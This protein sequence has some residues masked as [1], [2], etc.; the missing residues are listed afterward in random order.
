MPGRIGELVKSVY[1]WGY[2]TIPQKGCNNRIIT[3]PRGRLLGGCSAMNGTLLI[4]GVKADYDRI[5]SMGNPGWSWDEMMPFFRASETFHP[6][7]WHQA[8]L[9][10][11]GSSGPLHT[12]PYPLAPISE[13]VLQSFIDSGYDYKPDMFVQGEFEGL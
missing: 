2:D 11:H 8:D 10:V 9:S 5:A 6:T 7:E 12:E 1:D 13:K 3:V 4:R